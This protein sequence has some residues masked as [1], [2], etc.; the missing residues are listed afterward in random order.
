[1]RR[2]AVALVLALAA[3]GGSSGPGPVVKTSGAEVL[4][5]GRYKTYAYATAQNAP[6]GYAWQGA[7]RADV[8]ERIVRDI[9]AD[10]AGKGYVRAD[11]GELLVRVSTGRRQVTDE[12]TGATAVVGAPSHEETEGALVIDILERASGKQVFH[13]YAHDVIRGDRVEDAQIQKSVSKILEP[14]P[15][16]TR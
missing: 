13:G 14:V 7:P 9:D 6:Q 3:C 8:L 2:F 4:S 12:P 16:S 11:D 5:L 15:R 10:L 1:M